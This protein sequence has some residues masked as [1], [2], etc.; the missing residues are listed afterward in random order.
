MPARVPLPT[1][2]AGGVSIAYRMDGSLSGRPVV[3]LHALASTSATWTG[4]TRSLVTAGH[5]VI[6]PELRGHGGSAWTGDYR[7]DSVQR[8]VVSVLDL[9][10]IA[11]FDLIG[12]SLGAHI[13]ALL[14]G[15]RPDRVRKLVLEDPPPPP[16]SGPSRPPRR[17]LAWFLAAQGLARRSFDRRMVPQ[18]LTQL[19]APDPL[20][21]DGLSAIKAPTLLIGGS[22]SHISLERLE[23]VAAEIPHCD[24]L[25][26][27]AGHRIHSTRPTEFQDAVLRFL[28]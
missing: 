19:R 27:D 3:L 21:W 26:I 28:A 15:R 18:I 17:A 24:L 10:D 20:W 2:N 22:R 12:H 13:A 16:R 9:L 25:T 11:E 1:L 6:A 5:L 4:L 23:E 7:L 14:A 8:D